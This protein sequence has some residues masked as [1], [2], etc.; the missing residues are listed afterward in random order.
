MMEPPVSESSTR[1]SSVSGLPNNRRSWLRILWWTFLLLLAAGAGGYWYL[2]RPPGDGETPPRGFSSRNELMAAIVVRAVELVDRNPPLPENVEF[3]EGIPYGS[4]GGRPLLLDLYKPRHQMEKAP[5]LIFIHGG[6]WKSGSRED[7]RP[8]TIWFARQG[9]V[10]ATISYRLS[11]EA[12]FPAAVEDAKCAVRWMRS[13]AENLGV[14]P[15]KIVVIGGSAGGHLAMMV[16]YTADDPTLEGTGGHNNVSSA[17]A[18]VVDLYGPFDF[19][20]PEGKA[21]DVVKDFLG[22][23]SYEEAPDLWK[24]ASPAT[25]LKA[26]AP[27]TLILHGSIDDIVP[28]SQSETLAKR[29]EELNVPH[30]FERLEGWPHTMDLAVPVNVYC[31]R[32]IVKFLHEQ[33]GP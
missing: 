12:L 15:D 13:E 32:Q 31:R 18:A 29:L 14:D 27:P 2:S 9:Y 21:A 8:Y 23:R 11:K 28:I 3:H 24:R 1:D 7:Y 16:G 10:A 20:T 33:V 19:E 25:Y 4:G 5:G 6:G 22:K 26:G 17:V 30:R